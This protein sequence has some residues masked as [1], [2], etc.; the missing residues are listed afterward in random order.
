MNEFAQS[1]STL[2]MAVP[3][4]GYRPPA[5]RR[6]VSHEVNR[7]FNAKRLPSDLDCY[8][9]LT[10]HIVIIE[11]QDQ[12]YTAIFD[13]ATG[14]MS[15]DCGQFWRNNTCDH[16]QALLGGLWSRLAELSPALSLI[17]CT[18]DWCSPSPVVWPHFP[19]AAPGKMTAA[20]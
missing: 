8:S 16:L 17:A 11:N 15:C 4:D 3:G 13:P 14:Q 18:P 9:L 2:P 20:Q 19:P 12:L 5:V 7:P 6:R 1:S 10:D